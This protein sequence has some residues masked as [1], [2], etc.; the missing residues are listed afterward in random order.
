MRPNV[1]Y[2]DAN[3]LS[4]LALSPQNNGV[5]VALHACHFWD[6][7]FHRKHFHLFL[8]TKIL[9]VAMKSTYYLPYTGRLR[10]RCLGHVQRGGD[11]KINKQVWTE[12][13]GGTRPIEKPRMRWRYQVLGDFW[14]FGSEMGI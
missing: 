8:K 14:R 6:H 5:L 13:P 10:L 1:G 3:P 9:T 7:C 2:E 11:Y 12:R 4:S